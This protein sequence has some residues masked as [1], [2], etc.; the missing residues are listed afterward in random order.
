MVVTIT[1]DMKGDI[2]IDSD[3]VNEV[4]KVACMAGNFLKSNLGAIIGTDVAT[5]KT[6]HG[7]HIK[8]LN[9][10]R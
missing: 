10:E 1:V 9:G 5:N 2:L 3:L 4:E 7:N 6:T 8:A